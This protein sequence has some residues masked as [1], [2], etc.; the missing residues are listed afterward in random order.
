[1]RHRLPFRLAQADSRDSTDV[2]HARR[3]RDERHPVALEH[4]VPPTMLGVVLKPD[5]WLLMVASVWQVLGE[6]HGKV[7]DGDVG[8]LRQFRGDHD[9]RRAS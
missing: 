1:M 5:R 2:L 6:H 8:V 7:G 9:R 3:P 4:F